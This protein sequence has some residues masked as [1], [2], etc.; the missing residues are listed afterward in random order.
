[1][2]PSRRNTLV[3]CWPSTSTPAAYDERPLQARYAALSH[4]AKPNFSALAL[5]TSFDQVN[6]I[7][8]AVS[9]HV[10]AFGCDG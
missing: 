9:K 2:W 10:L 5:L 6:T 4:L 3:S 8:R 7:G 1:M